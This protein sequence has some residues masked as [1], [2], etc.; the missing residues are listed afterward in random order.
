MVSYRSSRAGVQWEANTVLFQPDAIGI[1]TVLLK[2]FTFFS[3]TQF[4]VY[5]SGEDES[6]DHDDGSTNN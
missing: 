5:S 4:D 6:Y 2:S 1:D 3:I